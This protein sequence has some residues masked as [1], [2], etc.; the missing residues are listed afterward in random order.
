MFEGVHVLV[1]LMAGVGDTDLVG[2]TEQ[3]VDIPLVI[4]CDSVGDRLVV[5]EVALKEGDK[6]LESVRVP[7]PVGEQDGDADLDE[8]GDGDELILQERVDDEVGV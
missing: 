1:W 2:E 8:T 3:D 4:E 7:E 6:N 5:H